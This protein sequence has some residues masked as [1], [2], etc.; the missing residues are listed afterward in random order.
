MIKYFNDRV[1]YFSCKEHQKVYNSY[2]KRK[3]EERESEDLKNCER[4]SF[5]G[6]NFLNC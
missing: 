3:Y 5:I 2:T 1:V 4:K 6:R